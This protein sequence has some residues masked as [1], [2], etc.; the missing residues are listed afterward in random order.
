[1][2]N[3]DH[4]KQATAHTPEPWQY[5]CTPHACNG[6]PHKVFV[7]G[8]EVASCGKEA[9][10][11]RIVAAVNACQGIPTK[12]LGQGVIRDLIGALEDLLA[13]INDLQG[14]SSCIDEDILQG[15]AYAA[16]CAALAQATGHHDTRPRQP[17]IIEVRGG[18]V[19]DV[20]N[21]PPG[22]DCEIRDYDNQ[23]ETA[24]AGRRE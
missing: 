20:L 9:N 12:A 11:R 17:I 7:D 19:Q 2:T 4:T 22:I 18:V 5:G 13:Q 6:L 3:T 8:E 16:A 21:L 1:M 24:E 15:K 10:A 14:E 23:D